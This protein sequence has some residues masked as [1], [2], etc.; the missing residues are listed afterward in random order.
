MS[1]KI[2]LLSDLHFEQ[3]LD[4]GAGFVKSL[5]PKGKDVLVLAGDI[6][7]PS[8]MGSLDRICERYRDAKV[9]WV[10]GN[11]TYYGS[12]RSW[13]QDASLKAQDKNPNLVWLDND[14]YKHMGVRFVG[15]PLWFPA[16]TETYLL[17]KN[18]SEFTMIPNWNSWVYMAHEEA[19]VFLY[20]NVEKGDVVI[21]HYLPSYR[22]VPSRFKLSPTNCFFVSD[23][24]EVMA[25]FEPQLWLHGH[26][27]DSADYKLLDVRVVCNPFGYKEYGCNKKFNDDFVIE[28]EPVG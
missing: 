12:E 17:S 4:G 22:S 23:Q 27:H 26:T 19:R 15:T 6:V 28:V 10:H 16:T 13:V 14:F 3:H 21:T 24:T 11:H 25:K 7:T 2:Q 9:I 8:T 5:N 20:K 1:V 18:W